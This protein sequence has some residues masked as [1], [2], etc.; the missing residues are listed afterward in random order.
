MG[1]TKKEDK[2][3]KKEV[4]NNKAEKQ[5]EETS[6]RNAE[7]NMEQE[8]WEKEQLEDDGKVMLDKGRGNHK[9]QLLSIIG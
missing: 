3:S 1:K 5:K 7:E 4:L 2:N 9:I 8:K 6:T